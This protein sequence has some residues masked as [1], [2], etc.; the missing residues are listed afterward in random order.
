MRLPMH[1]STDNS[2]ERGLCFSSIYSDSIPL[3]TLIGLIQRCAVIHGLPCFIIAP[4]IRLQEYM[5]NIQVVDSI[6]RETEAL[7]DDFFQDNRTAFVF[8]A[9]HGMSVIGNHGDGG[10]S[11]TTTLIG[12]RFDHLVADPDNTRTPLIAWGAGIRGP[13]ELETPDV[14]DEY[15]A[16]FELEH[17]ARRDVEQ[18][19]VA[20]I[21]STLIGSDW[22]V[23]CV[24]RL[25]DVD[26]SRPGYMDLSEEDLA[27]AGLNN[28]QVSRE[29][30]LSSG[31]AF[32]SNIGPSRSLCSQR[33]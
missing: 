31:Q 2:R 25:P 26:P 7:F 4:L 10:M 11:A 32:T 18:A 8:T 9:D 27:L 21:M 33:Q 19:D 5:D 16:P 17:L 29:V 24:G 14:P 22:P 12:S 3:A 28:M 6:V 1:P 30:A 13:I 15:S 23:N 20:A